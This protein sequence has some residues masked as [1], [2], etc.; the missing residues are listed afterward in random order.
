MIL[1]MDAVVIESEALKLPEIERAILVDRLQASLSQSQI[2]YLEDHLEES[3][4]RYEAYKKGEI[5][6]VDGRDFVA[7]LRTKI[8]S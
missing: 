7:D 4:S 5:D 8:G 6:A 3:R 2:T 1:S